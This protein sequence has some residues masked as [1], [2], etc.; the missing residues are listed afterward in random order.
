MLRPAGSLRASSPFAHVLP[1][2]APIT[3]RQNGTEARSGFE[4]GRPERHIGLLRATSL[5]VGAIVGGGV[6]ALAGTAFATAGPSAIL[7]FALNGAI[8]LATVASFVQLARRFPESGGI[9]AY[10]K[11]VFSIEVA[12]LVGWVVWFASVLAGVLYALGF[13]AFTAQGLARL[14]GNLG[15]GG[16]S[17]FVEPVIALGATGGYALLLTR[18]AA[19]GG[20]T[21]TVGKVVVLLAIVIGGMVAWVTSSDGEAW[22]RLSPFAAA[23]PLGVLQAMGFTFIALQGFDLIAAVGG[24]VRDPRKNIPRSMYISLGI[25]LLIYIPLLVVLATVGAPAGGI[26]GAAQANPEGLVAESAE[27]FLGVAGYWLVIL[28]GALSMLSALHANL[29]AASRVA[30]SMARDRTLPQRMGSLTARGTPALAVVVTGVLMIV[31]VLTVGDVASAGA[32]SSLIFLMAFFVVH[33]AAALVR[34]RTRLSAETGE[35][36]RPYRSI[37]PL[38]PVA[39]GI[40]CLGLAVFQAFAVPMAGSVVAIWMALGVASYATLLAPGA[41]LADASARARD[42]ELTGLRGQSPLVLAAVANPASAAGLVE[43]ATTVCAPGAG[44][45]MLLTVIGSNLES[46]VESTDRQG[47]TAFRILREAFVRGVFASRPPEVLF[48]I[49]D[50][51]WEEI[52]RVAGEHRCETVVLGLPNLSGSGIGAPLGRLISKLDTDIV[53]ARAPRG[54]RVSEAARILVPVSGGR[55]HGELR[56]RILSSLGRSGRGSVTFFSAIRKSDSEQEKRSIRRRVSGQV[57]KEALGPYELE[58]PETD[59]IAAATV[60]RAAAADLVVMGL[61]QSSEPSALSGS[62][63][64]QIV[65]EVSTPVILVGRWSRRIWHPASVAP[66]QPTWML[67]SR[68]R[69]GRP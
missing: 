39:G 65:A 12:F 9:Y 18:R 48:S 52:A 56:A 27:R 37:P 69:R 23:G 41:R 59:D 51:V 7:T 61:P 49:A 58:M 5:G 67:R 20:D 42:P 45:V 6:L 31:L 22:D 50:N 32:A 11:K 26:Q 24:E 46:L 57:G 15:L 4:S 60:E 47:S 63:P 8:A 13:A 34:S 40:A 54:W 53:I 43:I 44:R 17:S 66:R 38:L 3:A 62:L 64:L 1:R 14:L 21:A 33:L 68:G 35:R 16:W 28:A 29:F 55:A 2:F 10:A 30:F 25:A 19:G 36:G